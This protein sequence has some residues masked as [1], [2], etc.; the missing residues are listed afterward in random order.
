[1]RI[2]LAGSGRL[3]VGL[4]RA[5]S[6]SSHEVVAIVQDG[7]VNRGLWRKIVPVMGHWFG[8]HNSITGCARRKGIPL[9]WID[10]MDERELVPLRRLDIDVL[11]VGGFSIILKKPLLDLP[12]VGCLN[13]HSSL[14]PKHRG[15]NPFYAAIIFGDKESGVSF[16][17]M[18]PGIDSGAVLHQVA[19]E[20]NP[21][22]TMMSLYVRSCDLATEEIV[23]LMDR[24]AEEG[25]QG[26]PQDE[27]QA[28]YV[29]SPT[30]DD[31][32][33][34]WNMPAEHLDRMVRAMCPRIMPRFQWKGRQILVVRS[35]WEKGAENQ[36]APGTV[37]GLR[38]LR[39]A[40]GKGVFI[41]EGAF[42]KRPFYWLW[43][44]P[45][46]KVRVGNLLK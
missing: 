6:A 41:I 3:G 13:T 29:K 37:L 39:V 15:P 11:L 18:E 1:M 46:Q 17:V 7:R 30:V 5:L 42:V 12:K 9:V 14:L 24:I 40:T 36:Q 45:W 20:L 27:S 44:N 25:L 38:P 34:D 31:A 19:F 2:A 8:G 28:N 32:W 21:R 43:P 10:K 26:T 16:H 23:G 22:E 33:L 4:L 35:R